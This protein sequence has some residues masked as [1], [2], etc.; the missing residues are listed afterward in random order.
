MKATQIINS[1]K[2]KNIPFLKGKGRASP[3]KFTSDD[4]EEMAQIENDDQEKVIPPLASPTRL[5][6]VPTVELQRTPS[7][8]N[9]AS[10]Q[11]E[12]EVDLAI[13][14]SDVQFEPNARGPLG[15]GKKVN[16][17]YIYSRKYPRFKF[18]K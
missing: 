11:N 5:P 7:H 18:Y 10:K 14:E 9:V 13:G 8:E 4:D 1:H 6:K 16:D 17:S 3:S 2:L 12:E 15:I